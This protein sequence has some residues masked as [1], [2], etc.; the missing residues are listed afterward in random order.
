MVYSADRGANS[1]ERIGVS[2]LGTLTFLVASWTIRS[3]LVFLPA[4]ARWLIFA[5]ACAH[6]ALSMTSRVIREVSTERV[7]H[8][9]EL[10]ECEP[11]AA[12]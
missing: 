7:V 2:V 10:H 6:V 9:L 4:V 5:S 8:H 11:V 3:P 1:G 12:R